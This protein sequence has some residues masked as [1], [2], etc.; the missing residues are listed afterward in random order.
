MAAQ[1]SGMQQA[2]DDASLDLEL[3]LKDRRLI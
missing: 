1:R 3:F 2:I